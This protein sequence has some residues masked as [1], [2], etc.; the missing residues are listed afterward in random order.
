[1]QFVYLTVKKMFYNKHYPTILECIKLECL[2]LLVTS[3]LASY[4]QARLR[5]YPWSGVSYE[6]PT[7]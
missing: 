6:D 5:V 3:I 1:M 7:K 4:L 2:L